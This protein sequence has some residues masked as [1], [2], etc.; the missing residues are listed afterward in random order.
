MGW[1][2]GGEE[3]VEVRKREKSVGRWGSWDTKEGAAR[4]PVPDPAPSAQPSTCST[5]RAPRAS[6]V[7]ENQVPQR[8]E[9]RRK[10]R[11]PSGPGGVLAPRERSW[12]PG[13]RQRD[14]GGGGREGEM[15][16]KQ[17]VSP[18]L[19]LP[20]AGSV[21]FANSNLLEK[22]GSSFLKRGGLLSK[23]A[24]TLK[25]PGAGASPWQAALPGAHQALTP[26]CLLSPAPHFPCGA[27]QR[28]PPSLFPSPLCA[29]LPAGRQG[30][31]LLPGF[32]LEWRRGCE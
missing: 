25:K 1:R 31:D 12:V 15:E 21:I 13:Q 19:P 22:N 17:E 11:K 6:S 10:G 7:P 8:L 16:N 27:L 18:S 23:K 29:G 4:I 30:A 32:C 28:T 3:L 14:G 5:D 2:F 9:L 24:W 26:L 20:P